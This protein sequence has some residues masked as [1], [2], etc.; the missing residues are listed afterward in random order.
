MNKVIEIG[1][2]TTDPQNY[3]KVVKFNIAVDRKF[4]TGSQTADFIPIVC[5]GVMGE[6]AS[7]YFKKGMKVVVEGRIQTGS[8]TAKD[9]T[10]RYTFDVIAEN[11]EFAES[12]KNDPENPGPYVGSEEEFLDAPTNLPFM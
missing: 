1:R 3:E 8:Y 5:F 12:K 7:K 2:L 11:L 9:G 6:F 10:K 4:K